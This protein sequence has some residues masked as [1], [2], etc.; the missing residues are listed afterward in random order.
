MPPKTQRTSFLEGRLRRITSD[1]TYIAEI[2]GL[3]FIAIISVLMFHTRMMTTVYY[4]QIV[5][6]SNKL[7]IAL[8]T[9]LFHGGRGVELF[10]AVSGMVLGLPFARHCLNGDRVPSLDRYFKRR[11]TRLE[12]PYLLNLFLRFPLVLAA[13][14]L[15]VLQGLPHLVCSLFYLRG[16][17]YGKWPLTHPPS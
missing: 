10:F 1:G 5:P 4:G 13:Y 12:P 2:D 7:L 11:L 16:L 17:V 6:P 14:H 15:T 8:N 9:M 3:R